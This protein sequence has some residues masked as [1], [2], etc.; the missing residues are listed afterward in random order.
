MR[1][2]QSIFGSETT[3]GNY[4]ESLVKAAIERAVD[5]TDP[6]I[7]AVSGY[8]KKLRPAV[9]Q[10]IDYVV[11]LVDGMASP[12]VV[13]PGIYGSDTRLHTFFIS[14]T[15]MQKILASDRNLANFQRVQAA[16]LPR[17]FA[18]LAMEKKEKIILGAELSGDIVLRDVPQIAVSFEA[19]RLIDPAA[20][21]A[22]TRRQVKRRAYDHLLKL[23]LR[24][25][26]IMKTER[27][28]LERYRALLQSKH[29][30]LER[31]G[32]GFDKSSAAE[33]LDVVGVEDLL[34]RIE[35]Q[36]LDLG[37]DDH[38]LEVYLGIVA[39]VLSRPDEHLWARKE[40]LIVD[41]MGIKR[42]KADGDIPVV[43]LDMI[44][45]DEGRSLVVSLVVLS[46]N[47]F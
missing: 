20:T 37:G 6:W 34:G 32:W 21:E 42:S 15:D 33:H 43:T 19:H 13:E 31:E 40:T 7:R 39:D 47:V 18:L 30:L 1:L 10:A 5:G 44:S 22:E 12:I 4:P 46:S 14:N 35:T 25:I 38:M 3:P 41:R 45:N 27:D 24:R 2:F 36:M 23:A 28:N 26:T 29:D 16:A 11:A 9:V 17:V 8:K